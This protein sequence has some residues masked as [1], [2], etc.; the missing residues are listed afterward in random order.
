MTLE[1]SAVNV[2][3]LGRAAALCW[4]SG[5]PVDL[6]SLNGSLLRQEIGELGGDAREVVGRVLAGERDGGLVQML[7]QRQQRVAAVT[8][9]LAIVDLG[10]VENRPCQGVRGTCHDGWLRGDE[11]TVV[12]GDLAEVGG[13]VPD[14]TVVLLVSPDDG[15]EE[16]D[17]GVA[18]VP[19]QRVEDVHLHLGEH[20]S[21]VQTTAHV[22]ELVDLGDPVLLVTILGSDQE[23]CTA[24][25]LVVLLVDHPLRAVPVKQVDGQEEGFPEE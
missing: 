24:D 10:S 21:V 23:G 4:G 17:S 19:L 3:I 14:L 25:K 18:D 22:V 7:R 13:H 2:G 20:A 15:L 12:E 6:W 11:V 8:V 9:P 5:G 1:G 16:V